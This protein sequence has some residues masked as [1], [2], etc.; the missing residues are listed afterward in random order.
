MQANQ[1]PLV[2]YGPGGEQWCQIPAGAS[3]SA[4]DSVTIGTVLEIGTAYLHAG[5]SMMADG[6][7][8]LP[9]QT[10]SAFDAASNVVHLS[11]TSDA[12]RAMFDSAPANDASSLQA[13]QSSTPALPITQPPMPVREMNIALREQEV[14]ITILPTV[15]KDILVRRVQQGGEVTMTETIRKETARVERERD[16]S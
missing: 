3:L 12:V 4:S 10:I 14:V 6:D 2:Q 5:A 13:V 15:V 9:L 16:I 8:Y 11:V 1:T 7:V